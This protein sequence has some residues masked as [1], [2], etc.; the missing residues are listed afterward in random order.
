MERGNREARSRLET[1]IGEMLEG[2]PEHFHELG[3]GMALMM[4]ERDILECSTCMDA[5][6]K[7]EQTA[8]SEHLD[9]IPQVVPF[10]PLT[11]S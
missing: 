3:R 10:A 11:C 9:N 5:V 4:A 7:W 2:C 6:R 1:K 8:D